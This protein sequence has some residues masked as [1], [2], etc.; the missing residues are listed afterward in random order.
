MGLVEDELGKLTILSVNCEGKGLLF[1]SF[2]KA[3]DASNINVLASNITSSAAV[4]V[5]F[6][7]KSSNLPAE[8]PSQIKG[9]ASCGNILFHYLIPNTLLVFVVFSSGYFA[10]VD[11]VSGVI[12]SD[13][14]IA[15][16]A[17][18]SLKDFVS[19]TSNASKPIG[20]HDN[21]ILDVSYHVI[22]STI[23]CLTEP[24]V[25]LVYHLRLLDGCN[26][27]QAGDCRCTTGIV[28]STKTHTRPKAKG[29]SSSLKHD[30]LVDCDSSVKRMMGTID[31][32]CA[33]RIKSI[34]STQPDARRGHLINF[35][36]DGEAISISWGDES[37]EILGINMD[38]AEPDR[39]KQRLAESMY[40][41]KDHVLSTFLFMLCVLIV[42]SWGKLSK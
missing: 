42:W 41:G 20:H 29:S 7:M 16:Q 1:Y 24:G 38:D 15:K 22:T 14:D 21:F 37:V 40:L 9:G 34:P 27:L 11:W 18:H 12:L 17:H 8:V 19:R 6:S 5:N 33:R 3:L 28:T 39:L 4:E 36:A 35:S 32:L 2:P 13:V 31:F 30:N 10:L 25:V 23:A 26:N